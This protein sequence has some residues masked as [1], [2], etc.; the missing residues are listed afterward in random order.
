MA[1]TINTNIINQT[2]G[3]HLIDAKNVKGGYFVVDTS[4]NNITD[5]NILPKDTK[6]S[7]SLCYCTG[8]KKFYQYNGSA[9]VEAK[10]GSSI[11]E[12]TNINIT[13]EGKVSLKD[14]IN[15]TS[16]T[17]DEIVVGQLSKDDDAFTIQ[18]NSGN[19]IF[20]VDADGVTTHGLKTN[21]II[22]TK[23]NGV[24]VDQ[25]T[26][27]AIH[28]ITI[29]NNLSDIPDNDKGL[30]RYTTIIDDKETAS[31]I[32]EVISEFHEGGANNVF[33]K[34]TTANNNSIA[35][36]DAFKS[37]FDATLSNF[38]T[39]DS[40]SGSVYTYN[41]NYPMNGIRLGT[42][43]ATG[44][45]TVTLL[46]EGSLTFHRYFGF[47][48]STNT[49]TSYDASASV[50]IDGT[51]YNFTSNE[52]DLVIPVSAGTHTIKNV[53]GRILFLSFVF[54][55]E[56]YYTY[57]KKHLARQ[58][59]LDAKVE[60]LETA[61]TK[62]EDK[63]KT[64][65]KATQTNSSAIESV[66]AKLG[67]VQIFDVTKLPKASMEH[68]S[69]IY[70][71]QG[72]LNQCIQL[73][74]GEHKDFVFNLS[75]TSEIK[76]D[77]PDTVEMFYKEIDKSFNKHFE[78]AD[79]SKM[80]R[81]NG[82]IKLGSSSA[83]GY[84][85]I[86]Q[87]SNVVT[88]NIKLGLKAYNADKSIFVIKLYYADGSG[89]SIERIISDNTN[90]TIID[91]SKAI[92]N[93]SGAP[94]DHIFVETHESLDTG[95]G[96][97][98]YADSRG[99][100][101]RLI[102]DFGDVAYEWKAIEFKPQ[103]NVTYEE[104]KALRDNAQL[105]PGQQYRII[106]YV[107]TTSQSETCS[108][109]H[110]FDIIVT[111]DSKTV[112]NEN[113]K[114]TWPEVK[115][116]WLPGITAE[117][118]HILYKI[119]D[120]EAAGY[121]NPI[122]ETGVVGALTTVINSAGQTVP[123]FID[124]DPDGKCG[125]QSSLVSIKY[126]L[127]EDNEILYE[128]PGENRSSDVFV[129]L[130]YWGG[131]PA[132]YKTDPT[133]GDV[134][135]LENPDYTD[136]FAY[137]GDFELDGVNYNLWDKISDDEHVYQVLTD[138]VVVDNK[139]IITQEDLTNSIKWQYQPSPGDTTYVY[140]GSCVLDGVE[141]DQWFE[142]YADPGMGRFGRLTNKVVKNSD[143]YFDKANLAAWEIKYCL[144]N[145]T[146]RF[147][148]A[149]NQPVITN[150]ESAFSNGQG[151]IRMP[152]FDNRISYYKPEYPYAW[153][154]QADVADMDI[155]DFIY[156][157][158]EHLV[159]GDQVYIAMDDEIRE[160]EV[161]PGGKGVIYYMKDEH[162]NE[163]PYDFKNIQFLK[164]FDSSGRF[165]ANRLTDVEDNH[166]LYVYTFSI[167]NKNEDG[168]TGE[169]KDHSVEAST[170]LIDVDGDV[171]GTTCS[172]NNKILP[173]CLWSGRWYLPANVM[174]V[175]PTSYNTS[176]EDLEIV[177]NVFENNSTDN[178]LRSEYGRIENNF[179]GVGCA[180]NIAEDFLQD[181]ESNRSGCTGNVFK[182]YNSFNVV[183]G[184]YNTLGDSCQ[185]IMLLTAENVVIGNDSDQI[186]F[187]DP[188]KDSEVASSNSYLKLQA[189]APGTLQNITIGKGVSGRY[190]FGSGY[191]SK[192]LTFEP[193]TSYETVVRAAK[194]KEII[195]DED[196]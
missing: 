126:T 175:T 54:G 9:W 13:E 178:C 112:L 30:Y 38:V 55:G 25:F 82:N 49:I 74:D 143:R 133:N 130:G 63:I 107:A 147:D 23:L 98:T 131:I 123:A 137:K 77:N 34:T 10:L 142:T 161:A 1:L 158:T 185:G 176:D 2:E 84:I 120:G 148:W 194:Y 31:N 21:E 70:R 140:A 66:N 85:T 87:I 111:A 76:L 168:L 92:P 8:D 132:L 39:I 160:A 60:E 110:Q 73:G 46:Q 173:Y 41:S 146:E 64:V 40:I 37:H 11:S 153:G 167:L 193:N 179:F 125:Y 169:V 138:V 105:I 124:P 135:G 109:G 7:G 89:N 14:D 103:I 151:L 122:E 62:L 106:D 128:G 88:S 149:V 59:D 57:E 139:F 119:C 134:P 50:V 180:D 86:S 32:V 170:I 156:S 56:A 172:Y 91:L 104:L 43:S 150:I 101:T 28:P 152:S 96:E 183:R 192:V 52:E 51:T 108:A 33:A 81:N 65:E 141:Y 145:D 45:I 189:S 177:N 29:V 174:C 35:S 27:G 3:G 163:C 196:E 94:I 79:G 17:A 83:T 36:V 67:S 72:I 99:C 22:A 118:V 15:L 4:P 164:H 18:D 44:T 68:L 184:N 102:V 165:Y 24:D 80:F 90:E 95:D 191:I 42:K 129:E 12:G 117:D 187:R 71:C 53:N 115:D 162:N 48:G 100:V 5:T 78:I 166:Q 157:K 188:I 186:S 190:S 47:N 93:E 6:V 195:L 127:A 58:E 75:G 154:T 97:T 20:Q 144:D 61:D 114:A 69:N 26:A 16:V 155:A 181:I 19:A 136:V 171:G 159:S 116:E 113:A 182:S 121:G